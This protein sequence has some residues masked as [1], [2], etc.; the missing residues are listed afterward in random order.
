MHKFYVRVRKF[1]SAIIFCFVYFFVYVTVVAFAAAV[2]VLLFFAFVQ[3]FLLKSALD[4]SDWVSVCVY[5]LVCECVCLLICVSVCLWVSFSLAQSLY[6]PL[7]L[8]HS[9]A[10]RVFVCENGCVFRIM[11]SNTF[12]NFTYALSS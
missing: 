10:V 8:F 4:A 3:Q 7:S 9:F 6:L 11:D 2:V 12:S 1:E 5:V